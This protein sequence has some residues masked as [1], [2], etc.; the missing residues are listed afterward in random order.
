M[1]TINAAFESFLVDCAARNL[2]RST[3]R[4]YRNEIGKL[5]EFVGDNVAL[6][7]VTAD[8][9]RRFM[10]DLAVQPSRRE[11]TRPEAERSKLSPFSIHGIYRSVR[12]FFTWC[13][14]EDLLTVN[15]MDRIRAPKT[16]AVIVDRLDEGQARLFILEILRTSAPERN[17]ALVALML[18][19][20]L[21]RG[22]V[23]GLSIDDATRWRDFVF[24]R[25]G[26][27]DRQ[28][29][30]PVSEFTREAL[31]HYL[32]VRP[33][34]DE[35]NLFLLADGRPVRA[36]VVRALFEQIRKRL[37]LRRLY[38]HLLRHTF[39]SLYLKNGGDLKSLSQELGHSQ[40]STTADIYV[41]FS[42]DDLAAIH[43]RASPLSKLH[44]DE[45]V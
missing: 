11:T 35:N 18:D 12:T 40:E 36:N 13:L 1:Q 32:K 2:S 28:R 6:G 37:K 8:T 41:H 19:S 24:V 9:L 7:D 31:D 43:R 17:L 5:V 26:K 38:P 44:M 21:R 25:H 10:A 39:A 22:E 23:I 33:T 45:I 20:G 4:R 30:V 16:P 14:A 27:G 29:F 34:G 3:Q 15:P 42:P